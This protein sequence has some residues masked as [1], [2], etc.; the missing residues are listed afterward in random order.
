MNENEKKNPTRI[1]PEDATFGQLQ[2]VV[3]KVKEDIE[4]EIA[5]IEAYQ[6]G[7]RIL[8]PIMQGTKLTLGDAEEILKRLPK[9]NTREQTAKASGSVGGEP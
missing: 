5:A 3:G 6:Q 2:S 4:L 1:R 8:A 9:K 7:L